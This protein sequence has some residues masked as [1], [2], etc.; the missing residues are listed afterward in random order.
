M[1][2]VCSYAT[3]KD[4][5]LKESVDSQVTT[6]AKKQRPRAQLYEGEKRSSWKKS[7]HACRFEVRNCWD[8][9]CFLC[10][11]EGLSSAVR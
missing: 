4:L 7:G 6:E 9:I 3:R 8:T 1:P 10:E 5:V 2:W 11:S